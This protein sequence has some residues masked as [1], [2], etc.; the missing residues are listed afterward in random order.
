MADAGA[1][2]AE[3]KVNGV[4]VV[5]L[6]ELGEPLEHVGTIIVNDMCF[7]SHTFKGQTT[8]A[9]DVLGAFRRPGAR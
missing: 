2:Q 7:S 5:S 4:L 6:E 3:P 9:A 1:W 8:G